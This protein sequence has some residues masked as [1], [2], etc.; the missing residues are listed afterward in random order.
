M[1]YKFIRLGVFTVENIESMVF[2]H[3]TSCCL[4]DDNYELKLHKWN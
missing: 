3:A 1:F 2:W 4:A